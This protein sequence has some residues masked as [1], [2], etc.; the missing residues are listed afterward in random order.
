MNSQEVQC[1]TEDD[2][3]PTADLQSQVRD[4]DNASRATVVVLLAKAEC[5]QSSPDVDFQRELLGLSS[6][7]T[8][9]LPYFISPIT[10]TFINETQ[11]IAAFSTPESW[12]GLVLT[13]SRCVDALE[14]C[15]E[16]I[17]LSLRTELLQRWS[18]E[19]K[20][21]FT[22]GEATRRSLEA[23]LG[24][25]STGHQTGDAASLARFILESSLVKDNEDGK[26]KDQ[27][28]RLLYPCSSIRSDAISIALQ[29]K[30]LLEEIACYETVANDKLESEV[31]Q[32]EEFISFRKP[33]SLIV[34]FFSPSG[35]DNLLPALQQSKLL[36]QIS[37]N[38][39]VKWVAFGKVTAAK[40]TIQGLD[41]FFT[42]ST[43]TAKTLAT[44]LR[45]RL[46]DTQK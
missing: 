28:P 45:A 16:E 4:D 18:N 38:F 8:Q 40:M 26:L 39:L 22:V 27:L 15:L 11:L 24:L 31:Q 46:L 42:A 25:Q 29:G 19:S 1:S 34:V 21:I 7:S 32:L 5:S 36:Q 12:S 23:K 2:A 30:V 41:V 20:A 6:P 33:T 37:D 10:F 13:S 43:P 17:Q 35:V 9:I 44:D 3:T 14:R